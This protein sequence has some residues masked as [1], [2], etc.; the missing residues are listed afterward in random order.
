MFCLHEALTDKNVVQWLPFMLQ[1]HA[2]IQ[3]N[4]ASIRNANFL[5][6]VA[7]FASYDNSKNLLCPTL[8]LLAL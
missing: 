3:W 2:I 4:F 7:L 6:Q 1:D 8:L 5:I